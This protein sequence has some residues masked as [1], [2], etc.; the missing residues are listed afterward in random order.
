MVVSVSEGSLGGA[1][2]HEISSLFTDGDGSRHHRQRG[3]GHVRDD[4]VA[5]VGRDPR[6]RRDP[7]PRGADP[8]ASHWDVHVPRVR[9]ENPR[10]DGV[11]LRLQRRA[12]ARRGRRRSGQTPDVV[13]R[14]RR[15]REPAG[16]HAQRE[17]HF[18]AGDLHR[19]AVDD[20]SNPSVSRPNPLGRGPMGFFRNL[21]RG[22]PVIH[23]GRSSQ[24]HPRTQFPRSRRPWRRD[25][26]SFSLPTEAPL[27]RAPQT[28]R[29]PDILTQCVEVS[30]FS[31]IREK[32]ML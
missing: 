30:G 14:P 2:E 7:R 23:V 18:S 21:Q 31:F 4:P 9:G 15:Q 12:C 32:F 6:L 19:S 13:G 28:R 8:R 26:R 17:H 5:G 1:S 27:K 24:R 22:L 3:A 10:I 11:G 20:G 29:Q 16:L 25:P